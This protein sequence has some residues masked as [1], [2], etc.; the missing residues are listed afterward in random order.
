MGMGMMW[1]QAQTA[2]LVN[3]LTPQPFAVPGIQGQPS[4]ASSPL[5]PSSP[6]PHG[7]KRTG[8]E[9][10]LDNALDLAT[11]LP[12]LDAHPIRGKHH[13]YFAQYVEPFH[14]E[15]IFEVSDLQSFDI[16]TLKSSFGLSLGAAGRLLQFANEDV[17][18][19]RVRLA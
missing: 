9:A 4:V 14:A 11:W 10:D 15:D 18:V 13:H 1:Q 7:A 2:H 16:S 12:S 6:S 5:P 19:K 3:A 8:D 17:S